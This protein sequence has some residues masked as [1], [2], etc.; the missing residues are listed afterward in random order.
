MLQKATD[1]LVVADE[2]KTDLIADSPEEDTLAQPRADF[3]QPWLELCQPKA[4]RQLLRGQGSDEEVDAT[5]EFQLL[6][7]VEAAKAALE[8]A[9]ERIAHSQAPQMPQRVVLRA[10]RALTNT[11]LRQVRQG[12]EFLIREGGLGY[13]GGLRQANLAADNGKS[14]QRIFPTQMERGSDLF[15]QSDLPLGINGGCME[16]GFHGGI[17]LCQAQG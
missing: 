14:Y 12:G 9:I 6:G 7:R 5:L 16:C 15:R 2:G 1:F 8:G 13:D 3:P 4:R 11:T 17:S 10:E